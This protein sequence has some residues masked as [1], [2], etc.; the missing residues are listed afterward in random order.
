MPLLLQ[1]PSALEVLLP[2]TPRW[3]A[4]LGARDGWFG[5]DPNFGADAPPLL[6]LCMKSRIRCNCG[7]TDRVFGNRKRRDV[8]K[9]PRTSMLKNRLHQVC[10]LLSKPPQRKQNR[11][12]HFISINSPS[13]SIKELPKVQ[14]LIKTPSKTPV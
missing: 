6:G 9:P 2:F 13:T 3:F 10:V 5:S 8:T 4:H 1:N 14:Q 11:M 7:Y 12:P